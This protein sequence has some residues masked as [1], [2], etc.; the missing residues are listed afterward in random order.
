MPESF[1][2][3][4]NVPQKHTAIHKPQPMTRCPY[5]N[6]KSKWEQSL[7]PPEKLSLS[8]Q[9]LLPKNNPVKP[10]HSLE[11]VVILQK[12][13]DGLP[14]QSAYRFRELSPNQGLSFP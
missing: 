4:Q 10:L 14:A 8:N 5:S 6:L 1:A 12:N 13:R 9:H 7:L 3:V 11:I 2:L